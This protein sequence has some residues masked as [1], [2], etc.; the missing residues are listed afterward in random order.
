[1]GSVEPYWAIKIGFR[2]ARTSK[3]PTLPIRNDDGTYRRQVWNEAALQARVRGRG[4]PLPQLCS[5]RDG[6][7]TEI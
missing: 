3:A 1:M 5:A 7:I 4:Q 2:N 6:Y